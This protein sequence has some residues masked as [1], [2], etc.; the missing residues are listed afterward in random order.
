MYFRDEIV[1]ICLNYAEIRISI[2]LNVNQFLLQKKIKILPLATFAEDLS[3]S[4]GKLSWLCHSYPHPVNNIKF[5]LFQT[6]FKQAFISYIY[7]Y[8]WENRCWYNKHIVKPI[9]YFKLN[10]H[11]FK[12]RD[13]EV[14]G[15]KQ[16]ISFPLSWKIN[17]KLNWIFKI[18]HFHGRW[19]SSSNHIQYVP[20]AELINCLARV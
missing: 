2:C 17:V 10:K 11:S 6:E 5:H 14:T 8:I 3:S 15:K 18:L 12:H 13:L 20:F 1:N 9:I 4:Q 19:S 7:I 16:K